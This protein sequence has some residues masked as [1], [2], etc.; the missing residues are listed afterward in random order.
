MAVEEFGGFHQ[1][2]VCFGKKKYPSAFSS[3]F[4]F[5]L[6]VPYPV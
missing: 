6:F 5:L 4:L 1:G 3:D 2:M